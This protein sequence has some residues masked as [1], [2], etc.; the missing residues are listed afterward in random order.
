MVI[1]NTKLSLQI[2]T[3]E[4][5]EGE[6]SVTEELCAIVAI[7]LAFED[8]NR[9]SHTLETIIRHATTNAL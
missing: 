3:I 8:S 7:G 2:Q 5:V 4:E 9:V 1:V 6:G